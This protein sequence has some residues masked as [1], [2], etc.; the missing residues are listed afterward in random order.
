MLPAFSLQPRAEVSSHRFDI[1]ALPLNTT[2]P[3]PTREDRLGMELATQRIHGIVR[4]QVE[5]KGIDEDRI[6]LAGFS[7]GGWC[8]ALSHDIT[9][10]L[11]IAL[12][13]Y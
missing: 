3:M 13:C 4:D 9:A 11:V 6:V 8:C 1:L 7:Q 5:R 2:S 10:A 12:G